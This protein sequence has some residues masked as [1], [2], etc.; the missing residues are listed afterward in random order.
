MNYRIL[1]L[2]LLLSVF[3]CSTSDD[4]N[5]DN[6]GSC[7][8]DIP[9]VV[10]GNTWTSNVTTFGFDAGQIVN[11]VIG[12]GDG[13]MEVLI[14]S[15]TGNIS[16]NWKQEDGFLWTDANNAVD[17]FNRFYKIDAQ[18]GDTFSYTNNDGAVYTTEVIAVDST[19]TVP[20]GDFVC[21]VYRRT[22]TSII[23]EIFTMW[24]HDIGQIKSD[25][26]FTVFE[27]ASYNFD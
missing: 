27:L 7:E 12:C 14:T 6:Q 16:S 4:S 8:F 3:N 25:S 20:A 22:S 21:D 15:P 11:E 18:V 24:N 13:G 5:N 2:C 19:I 10:P 23:N 9:F 26:G 17:G 1:A